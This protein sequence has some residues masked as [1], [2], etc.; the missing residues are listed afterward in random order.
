MKTNLKKI[1]AFLGKYAPFSNSYPC[2]VEY[3][4]MI[5]PSAEHAFQAAKTKDR[6]LRMNCAVCPTAKE[7]KELGNKIQLRL[8]WEEIKIQVMTEIV[9]DKFFRNQAD[10]NI[11]K[12]LLHT[13]D[14]LLEEANRHG[15]RFWGTVKG[16][17]K[18]W[19]GKVLMNVRGELRGQE[20]TAKELR[21]KWEQVIEEGKEKFLDVANFKHLIFDTYQYFY[22]LKVYSWVF[23]QDLEI[24]KYA[25]SF[26][27]M[28]G[29]YPA[30]CEHYEFAACLDFAEGLC[31]SI[32]GG[33]PSRYHQIYLP[34]GL[35]YHVPA[36]C[37]VSEADMSSYAV[38]EE[39]F[40]R[41]LVRLYRRNKKNGMFLQN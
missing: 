13:G 41:E 29:S 15:D 23:R 8:D 33:F 26:C 5:F 40:R 39:A 17:G 16:E 36:G 25:G 31:A 34:L 37:S 12:L 30:N 7:A 3:E 38:Y 10:K 14:A 20:E 28:W 1:S 6:H 22:Q 4:G 9:R 2:F 11:R 32:E 24:Y 18:N 21:S 27:N 35:S 19:L